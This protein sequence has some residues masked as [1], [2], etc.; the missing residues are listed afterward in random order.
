MRRTLGEASPLVVMLLFAANLLLSGCGSMKETTS[1]PSTSPD[2]TAL[3]SLTSEN[4]KL[5]AENAQLKKSNAQLEQD[6]K[7]LNAKVA[8]LTSKLGQSSQQWQ[9][10][11]DLQNRAN[12]L[13]SELTIQKQ[14]NR[15]LSAKN[16]ELEKQLLGKGTLKEQEVASISPAEFKAKYLDALKLFKNRKYKEALDELEILVKSNVKTELMSNAHYWRGEC[17]YALG[18][19]G[20]A[21]KA[22]ETTLTYKNTYKR[23]AAYV[24]LGMSYLRLGEKNKART[25]FEELLKKDK[26]SQYASRA[27][28]LLKELE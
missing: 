28:Q 7:A 17:Y 5:Q 15:D 18:K 9:D 11:V 22:F 23:G 8:D 26:T 19:Y 2:S 16:A 21:V 27:R 1:A 6:K 10:L 25:A 20:E 13:D 24:M 4:Q 3:I 12:A 14:I